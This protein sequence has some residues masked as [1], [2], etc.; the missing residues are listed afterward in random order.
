MAL[1]KSLGQNIQPVD[2]NGLSTYVD[3][4]DGLLKLKD[5]NGCVSPMSTYVSGGLPYFITCC[6]TWCGAPNSILASCGTETCL[7]IVLAP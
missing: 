5:I 4:N 3:D 1:T 6:N 7:P 2:G